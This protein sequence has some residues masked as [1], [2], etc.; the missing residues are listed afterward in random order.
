[1]LTQKAS[2]GH[3]F[4]A[5]QNRRHHQLETGFAGFLRGEHHHAQLQEGT[6]ASQVI[7]TRTADLGTAGHIDQAQ[8]FAEFQVVFRLEIKIRDFADA[9]D[10]DEVFFAARWCAFDDIRQPVLD[11]GDLILGGFLLFLRLFDLQF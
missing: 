1:M 5:H 8:F 11:G 10:L 6:V 2:T 3:N 9:L 7:K 4:W